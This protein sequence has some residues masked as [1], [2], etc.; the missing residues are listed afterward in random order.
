MR[1]EEAKTKRCPI[2][3]PITGNPVTDAYYGTQ[4]KCI[5]SDCALG[6]D[7]DGKWLGHCGLIK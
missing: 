1:E 7:D 6:C 4:Q 5:A 3:P 2:M